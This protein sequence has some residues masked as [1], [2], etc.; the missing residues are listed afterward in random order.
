[1]IIPIS[2]YHCRTNIYN[3]AYQMLVMVSTM[4]GPLYLQPSSLLQ[5]IWF[6]ETNPAHQAKQVTEAFT[7]GMAYF[8]KPKH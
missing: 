3:T 2:E 7:V 6:N 8:G 1:M 5:V 4:P